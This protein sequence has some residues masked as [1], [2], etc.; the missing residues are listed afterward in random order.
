MG[1][2]IWI[3]HHPR[4][5]LFIRSNFVPLNIKSQTSRSLFIFQTKNNSNNVVQTYKYFMTTE[6]WTYSRCSLVLCIRSIPSYSYQLIFMMTLILL[7][8]S[9]GK[10]WYLYTIISYFSWFYFLQRQQQIKNIDIIGNVV[11]F[12]VSLYLSLIL[13]V[14]LLLF[15]INM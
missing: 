5:N 10:L 15:S 3:N 7:Y 4:S 6:K 1:S 14:N 9:H 8:V 12:T 13:Q 2:T 11:I